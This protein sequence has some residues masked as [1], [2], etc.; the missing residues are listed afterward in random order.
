MWSKL[1]LN[2]LIALLNRIVFSA[3]AI[4]YFVPRKGALYKLLQGNN[5]LMGAD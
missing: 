3:S 4:F 1:K 2:S 5:L